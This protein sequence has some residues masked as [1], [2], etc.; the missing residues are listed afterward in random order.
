[1]KEHFRKLF[2]YDHWATSRMV[3]ALGSVDTPPNRSLEL[4]DHVITT[5]TYLLDVIQHGDCGNPPDRPIHSLTE[6]SQAELQAHMDWTSFL[7]GASEQDLHRE[8]HL[9]GEDGQLDCMV[10]DL[11]HH[12]LNHATHHRAQIGTMLRSLGI[13]PPGLDYTSFCWTEPANG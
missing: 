8:L 13:A 9:A 12:A 2:D 5:K 7:T 4:L 11:C 6:S 10:A 1:M 3:A